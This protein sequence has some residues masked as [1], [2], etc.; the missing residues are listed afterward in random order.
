MYVLHVSSQL[1]DIDTGPK[2]RKENSYQKWPKLK[3]RWWR[4]FCS[5]L[6]CWHG[7]LLLFYDWFSASF[8]FSAKLNV[9]FVRA[10]KFCGRHRRRCSWLVDCL[11]FAFSP[12]IHSFI[13]FFLLFLLLSPNL[14]S[15]RLDRCLFFE[16]LCR[17]CKNAGQSFG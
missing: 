6:Y 13:R 1:I 16:F 4:C 14:V 12:L 10:Y 15:S 11:V 9:R 3:L 5:C 2:D 17:C 8:K 7:S